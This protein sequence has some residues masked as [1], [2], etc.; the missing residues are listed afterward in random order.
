MNNQSSL[1]PLND[2]SD[3]KKGETN[4]K[5]NQ[6]WLW[7]GVVIALVSPISGLILGIAFWTESKLKKEAKI[8]LAIA[9]VWGIVA[10][11]LSQW[12]TEQGYLPAY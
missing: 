8:I 9:I 5:Y 11:Y 6:K 2:S 10:I 7:L 12:L 4:L 1:S 3:K